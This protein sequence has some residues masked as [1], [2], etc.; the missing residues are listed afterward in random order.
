[1]WRCPACAHNPHDICTQC[2]Q[3]IWLIECIRSRAV[4]LLFHTMDNLM[5]ANAPSSV[6]YYAHNKCT[7]CY[8]ACVQSVYICTAD[9][10]AVLPSMRKMHM[11]KARTQC[12][13]VECVLYSHAIYARHAVMLMHDCRVRN[14]HI[15]LCLAEADVIR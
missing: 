9:T 14:A 11:I 3:I 1:M 15:K 6:A 10:R 13:D 7:Q 2:T 5:H 4:V 8:H 12:C